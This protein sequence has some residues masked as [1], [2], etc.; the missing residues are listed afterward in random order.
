MSMSIN[1]V[2]KYLPIL[3]A[4]YKKNALTAPLEVNPENVKFKNANKVELFNMTMDGLG[5]Y[6]RSAGYVAGEVGNTWEEKTLTID[7]GRSF[8]VD[9]MDDEETILMLYGK[10]VGEF[11]RTHV[12]PEI[13]AYRFATLA[14]TANIGGAAAD[15]T[16]GTTDITALLDT[17]EEYMGDKEV[18]AEGRL[19]YVSELCYKALKQKGITRTIANENGV[20]RNIE[21]YNGMEVRRVPKA[22]FCTGITLLD[23]STEGQE[24]GGYKFT[25]GTSK[26]INFMIVHPSAVT[27][28]TKHEVPRVFNPM[29][30]Q[31]ANAWRFDYRIYHDI[32]A[33]S[34]KLDGIYVHK[35]STALAA[36]ITG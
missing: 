9:V 25:S 2:T 20:N 24:G 29:V 26:P 14:G 19:L 30:N 6:S 21:V 17:A 36:D 3:D 18:P 22:R 8:Q 35:A 15:I 23:G 31:T 4:I 7:R 34:K 11:M 13:D 27:A 28:I 33:L 12:I 1:L 32:F 5:T 16:A 10:L